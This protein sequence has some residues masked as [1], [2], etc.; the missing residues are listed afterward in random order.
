VGD[1]YVYERLTANPAAPLRATAEI[2]AFGERVAFKSLTPELRTAEG[3]ALPWAPEAWPPEAFG[4]A[5]ALGA[6]LLLAWATCRGD[7]VLVVR[8]PGQAGLALLV[9][10]T[11]A[12]PP[13]AWAGG[14]GGPTL[15]WELSDPLGT[16][17]VMLNQHGARI[18]HT[19]FTPF[20]GLYALVGTGEWFRKYYAGH[21]EHED[22]GLY[23][24]Q[25]RWYDPGSGTFLSID[26]VVADAEDPQAFNA[27]SYARNNPMRYVDPTG[28][29]FWEFAIEWGFWPTLTYVVNQAFNALESPGSGYVQVGEIATGTMGIGPLSGGGGGGVPAQSNFQLGFQGADDRPQSTESADS[30]V[31]DEYSPLLDR[32]RRLEGELERIEEQLLTNFIN[33]H[34]ARTDHG[35]GLVERAIAIQRHLKRR[36]ALREQ[37]VAL[38]QRL[39]A[40]DQRLHRVESTLRDR[41][42]YPRKPSPGLNQ[43]LEGFLDRTSQESLEKK[44]EAMG[45]E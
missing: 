9:A 7:L 29:S 19:L 18:R 3:G 42:G 34:I 1:S 28:T 13:V 16:G 26:P 27:Y 43:R 21:R 44:L 24:M 10:T 12:V 22:L 23:Y 38:A 39:D 4:G 37:G 25:A 45:I 30:D 41:R 5:C 35:Y 14:G 36:Y 2:R 11:L 17:M 8:Q 40:L 31:P 15:R 20:G 32:I 33:I 6:L